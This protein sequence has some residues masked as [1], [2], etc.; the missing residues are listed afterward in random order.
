MEFIFDIIARHRPVCS[1]CVQSTPLYLLDP[2]TYSVDVC[3]KLVPPYPSVSHILIP[4][5]SLPYLKG[6]RSPLG[7]RANILQILLAPPPLSL[8]YDLINYGA[9][10]V[11]F[12]LLSQQ[13]IFFSIQHQHQQQRQRQRQRQK[14]TVTAPNNR[15]DRA[16]RL[17]DQQIT[18]HLSKKRDRT[19][20]THNFRPH[21]TLHRTAPT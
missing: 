10:P 14:P 20:C 21:A 17:A 19:T 12:R 5:Y 2:G 11:I 4:S 7:I 16:G 1:Y 3:T 18:C 9:A 13:R 8:Y 6:Y 15:L